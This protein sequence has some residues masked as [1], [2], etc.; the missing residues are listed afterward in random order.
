MSCKKFLLSLIFVLF[1]GVVYLM[2]QDKA[3]SKKVKNVKPD[4]LEVMDIIPKKEVI[5]LDGVKREIDPNAFLCDYKTKKYF[6]EKYDIKNVVEKK[7][8]KN[9]YRSKAYIVSRNKVNYIVES[10]DVSEGYYRQMNPNTGKIEETGIE[11]WPKLHVIYMKNQNVLW[12]VTR[13]ASIIECEI[14]DDGEYVF[15]EL[16]DMDTMRGLKVYD[17]KGIIMYVQE[18]GNF[19]WQTFKNGHGLV[20]I[21]KHDKFEGLQN[22]K[23]LNYVDLD[24]GTSWK[25]VVDNDQE[26]SHVSP[27]GQY[28][29]L[30]GR[31][32]KNKDYQVVNKDGT[33]GCIINGFVRGVNEKQQLVS[34]VLAGLGISYFEKVQFFDVNTCGFQGQFEMPK[35]FAGKN[36]QIYAG[37][38]MADSEFKYFAL[39]TKAIDG[40]MWG[41]ILDNQGNIV[42]KRAFVCPDKG[43]DA[44]VPRFI[45]NT[46]LITFTSSRDEARRYILEYKAND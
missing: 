29:F 39:G 27:D 38:A 33:K 34:Y 8:R 17:K 6:I 14:S 10:Y 11:G 9:S 40:T 7:F 21:R 1:L 42:W 31:G 46:N 41:Y 36:V 3:V 43:S 23:T 15:L 2:P 22:V 4:K 26:L 18:K 25:V 19:D 30:S 45:E 37:F 24:S 32:P 28:I 16:D 13:T 44:I 5:I 20:C 35:L 12:S